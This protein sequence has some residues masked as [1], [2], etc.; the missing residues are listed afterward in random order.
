MHNS[1]LNDSAV[2]NLGRAKGT[3]FT[4][5]RRSDESQR[6]V[7]LCALDEIEAACFWLEKG[8]ERD[9][10]LANGLC[11]AAGRL[12]ERARDEPATS[13]A[14]RAQLIVASRHLAAARQAFEGDADAVRNWLS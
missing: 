14:Q 12:L 10:A 2:I 1:S 4:A 8:Q 6:A 11:V 5:L 13:R 9:K 7:L 3:L